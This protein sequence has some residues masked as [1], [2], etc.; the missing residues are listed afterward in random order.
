MS[1]HKSS[2]KSKKLNNKYLK[3]V[4]TNTSD[5]PGFYALRG[6]VEELEIGTTCD[7]ESCKS[8]PD[9][10]CNTQMLPTERHS[11]V[12]CT[13]CNE[14]ESEEFEQECAIYTDAEACVTLFDAGIP[15]HLK[16]QF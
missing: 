7:S 14:A 6:C 13:N 4:T 10:N 1:F 3:T 11:C 12:Q 15:S 16:V 9:T 2:L 5:I 8:C